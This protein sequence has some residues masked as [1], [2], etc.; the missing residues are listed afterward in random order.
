MLVTGNRLYAVSG[1][2]E[3]TMT[4]RSVEGAELR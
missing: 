1:W 2:S 3:P 4:T